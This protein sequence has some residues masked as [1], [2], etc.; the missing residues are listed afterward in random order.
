LSEFSGVKDLPNGLEVSSGNAIS[1]ITALRDDVIRVAH[2]SRRSHPEDA[3]WAVLP[4][5]LVRALR[6][7]FDTR[8]G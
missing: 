3:S 6:L 7:S 1:Q 2:R 4:T 8:T 5:A